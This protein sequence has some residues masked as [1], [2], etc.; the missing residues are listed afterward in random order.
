M[1]GFYDDL[2]KAEPGEYAIFR[3]L[4]KKEADYSDIINSGLFWE[5]THICWVKGYADDDYSKY[6]QT[7]GADIVQI[8]K[9]MKATGTASIKRTEPTGK[10][11]VTFH[12]VKTDGVTFRQ[13]SLQHTREWKGAVAVVEQLSTPE[14]HKINNGTGN[15]VVEVYSKH[16]KK[17]TLEEYKRLSQVNDPFKDKNAGWLWKYRNVAEKMEPNSNVEFH[18]MIWWYLIPQVK[19]KQPHWLIGKRV[20]DLVA[21]VDELVLSGKEKWKRM[22]DSEDGQSKELLLIPLDKTHDKVAGLGDIGIL[23]NKDNEWV[24]GFTAELFRLHNQLSGLP[25]PIIKENNAGIV[26]KNPLKSSDGIHHPDG[27]ILEKIRVP[28]EKTEGIST[29]ID[30]IITMLKDYGII[31]A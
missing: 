9:Q 1:E 3:R 23:K 12:E 10:T 20:M 27:N 11:R 30:E 18:S 14:A 31:P 25:P 29:P 5:T 19:D 17:H 8:E 21:K 2:A 28:Y 24:G 16:V 13:Y 6:L 15:I 4:H 26:I 22:I 7:R